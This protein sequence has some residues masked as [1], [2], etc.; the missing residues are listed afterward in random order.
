MGYKVGDKIKFTEE[1][2]PYTIRAC[3]ERYLICT[4]PFNP[5]HTVLY[6]IVDLQEKIRGRNWWIFNI[7]DY[8]DD[9]GCEDCLRDLLSGECE[10]SPRNRIALNIEK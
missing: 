3:N 7:Y 10:I 8:K 2:R 6:S 9:E 4:K 1:K 5:L